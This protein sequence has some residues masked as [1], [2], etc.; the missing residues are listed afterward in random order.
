MKFLSCQAQLLPGERDVMVYLLLS[1]EKAEELQDL[2]PAPRPAL[3]ALYDLD[4]NGALSP[5][6][7]QKVFRGGEDFAG[8]GAAFLQELTGSIIPTVE[9]KP[10]AKRILAGYSMGGLFA[11]YAALNTACFDRVASVSGS[12]WFD[13]FVDYALKRSCL[14]ERVYLSLGDKEKN[15][16][17]PRMCAIEDCTCTVAK[18]LG[19]DVE[20]NPGGHFQDELPRL[21]RGIAALL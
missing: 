12:L 18:H 9:K 15:T 8:G 5:W 16:R 10:P 13:G 4:W 7:A 11:L 2:L 21:A 19:C 20:L 1:P 17:N 6:P 14:A 3:A